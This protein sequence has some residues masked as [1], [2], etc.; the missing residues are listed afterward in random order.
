MEDSNKRKSDV[1]DGRIN[2]KRERERE[3]IIIEEKEE[4][5]VNKEEDKRDRDRQETGGRGVEVTD[6]WHSVHYYIRRERN[7]EP[8]LSP[9]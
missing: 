7:E 2:Q 8:L 4:A 1:K 6:D 5:Q 9:A 3:D